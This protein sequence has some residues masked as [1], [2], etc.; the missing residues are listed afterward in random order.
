MVEITNKESA[1]IKRLA[2]LGLELDRLRLPPT[3]KKRDQI[4]GGITGTIRK[5]RSAGLSDDDIRRGVR[6]ERRRRRR[7]PS[8]R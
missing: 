1:L 8:A 3:G 6:E 7:V 5:L 4:E 2:A